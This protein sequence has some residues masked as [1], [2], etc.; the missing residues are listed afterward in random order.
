[1]ARTHELS[2]SRVALGAAVWGGLVLF[3]AYAV[4]APT[5]PAKAPADKLLRYATESPRRLTVGFPRGTDLLEG[6][7]VFIRDPEKFLLRIGRIESVGTDAGGLLAH[8]SIYPEHAGVLLEGSGAQAFEV[9]VGG[10]WVVST[11]LPPERL[12]SIREATATFFEREGAEFREALWPEL[13]KALVD[14]IALYEEELPHALAGRSEQWKSIYDRHRE[15][16]IREKLV[17]AL[18]EVALPLLKEEFGPF[19][20][21]VGMELW[22]ELPIWSLGI[23]YV[24]ERVPGTEE[25]QVEKKFNEY[26]EAR[27][28]PILKKH[29]PEAMRIGGTVLKET[30]TAPQVREALAEVA[31]ALSEDPELSALLRELADELILENERLGELVKE[32]WETGLKAAVLDAAKKLDPLTKEVVNSIVLNEERNGINPRLA[33]V[34]RT[35]VFRKDGRWVLLLPGDGAP[36]ADGG[37]ITGSIYRE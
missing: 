28:S 30:L 3:V 6:D 5:G 19:L 29:A 18:E 37:R 25:D 16:V 22:C 12:R 20:E 2:T 10:P 17:P 36:L 34:L 32:R 4:L 1:M 9:S 15:G 26:L 7:P 11:L 21:E 33:Q 24:L 13:K 31:R 27:A 35:A 14:V 8:L 23:R